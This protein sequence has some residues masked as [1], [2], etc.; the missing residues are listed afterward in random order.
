MTATRAVVN[1]AVFK[2]HMSFTNLVPKEASAK[3]CP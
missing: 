2:H 3:I 1:L